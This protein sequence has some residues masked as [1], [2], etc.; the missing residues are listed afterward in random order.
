MQ[1]EIKTKKIKLVPKKCPRIKLKKGIKFTYVGHKVN[2]NLTIWNGKNED[3][4][5]TSEWLDY[6]Q[7]YLDSIKV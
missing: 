5:T 1:T 3:E 6:F 7:N 2:S 4:M